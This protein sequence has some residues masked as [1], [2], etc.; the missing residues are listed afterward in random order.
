M[1]GLIKNAL[2]C[3]DSNANGLC[4]TS[5]VQGRTDANGQV[6]L[7]VPAADVATAKL[8]AMV[9]T[10]A[11]DAD[12][13]AVTTAYTLTTPVGKHGVI[14]P[15]TTLAQ[16]KIDADRAAGKTTSADD[17]DAYVQ[18]ALTLKVSVFDNFVA[19]RASNAD[20]KKAGDVAHSL[21]V[22]AQISNCGWSA[23]TDDMAHDGAEAEAAHA[24]EIHIQ[25]GML[26]KL[27]AIKS[28]DFSRSSCAAGFTKTCDDYIKSQVT[29]VSTATC[30]A[31]P[32]TTPITSTTPPTPATPIAPTAPATPTPPAT[33]TTPMAP[34]SSAQAGKAL[35]AANC[36]MCH[37]VNPALGSNK[38]LRGANSAA[39]I[40]SAISSN[41]GGMKSLAN[42]ILAQQAA[43]LAAY[44]A[45]PGI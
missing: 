34:S 3:V 42:T 23:H 25:T 45:T 11:I 8:V 30:T 16:A 31:Q 43:D 12:T 40:L 5:E 32:G 39:T 37:G 20:F 35:Y 2:V 14:S 29:P 44:L 36:V 15:L 7:T 41:M 22:T 4:D 13:G 33:P 6:T 1:D 9:G 18:T 10:D 26:D 38:I 21:A 17:A 28:L 27:G 19:K 24:N